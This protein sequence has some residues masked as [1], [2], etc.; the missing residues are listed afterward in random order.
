MC[1]WLTICFPCKAV[2]Q[3]CRPRP[4][5]RIIKIVD[6]AVGEVGACQSATNASLQAA[7]CHQILYAAPRSAPAVNQPNSC[8]DRPS[9]ICGEI[10]KVCLFHCGL[11]VCFTL[12]KKTDIASWMSAF[13]PNPEIR[14]L[15][16]GTALERLMELSSV[17]PK[18]HRLCPR[19]LALIR[20]LHPKLQGIHRRVLKGLCVWPGR[21]DARQGF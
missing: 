3:T 4:P 8:D 16:R 12:K 20:K 13:L 15:C 9:P 7:V 11:N 10:S 19:F 21:A 14:R 5:L 6:R 1:S 17:A 18:S 2:F